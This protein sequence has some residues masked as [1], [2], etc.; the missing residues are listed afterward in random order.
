MLIRFTEDEAQA[1]I[2]ISLMAA[3][4]DGQSDALGRAE[5]RRHADAF[6]HAGPVH[7]PRPTRD[8]LVP[9]TELFATA[10]ALRSEGARQIAYGMAV[11]V[12]DA[13]GVQTSAE[14]QFLDALRT[15]LRLDVFEVPHRRA[16]TTQ[17]TPRIGA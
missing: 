12:C 13:D 5:I 9:P 2:S 11:C 1:V 15:V 16:L 14:R 10:G 3:S 6:T 8:V 17:A 4:L 7:L